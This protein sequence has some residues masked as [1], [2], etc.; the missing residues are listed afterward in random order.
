MFGDSDELIIR[1]FEELLEDYP[2]EDLLEQEDLTPAEALLQLFLA[3]HVRSPFDR[4]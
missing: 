1:K 4:E 3:G 2:L